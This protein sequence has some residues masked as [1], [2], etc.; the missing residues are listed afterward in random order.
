[1]GV[2]PLKL[3]KSNILILILIVLLG[4]FLRVYKLD[5][6]PPGLTWD[7][8]SLGYNAYSLSQTGKDEYGTFL[9]LTL[10][11][12]GD[13]KPALYAYL[14]I[15]FILILDLNEIAVR[16]PS[17]LAGIGLIIVTY[18][19][20]KHTFKN[21]WL[22]LSTALFVAITPL[23][24]QFSR[25]AFESNVAVFLNVLG[26]YI[27][28]KAL[29]NPRYHILAA[30]VFTLS[31]LCYQASK[32]FVPV[33]LVGL[34]L[35]FRKEIN[36]SKQLLAGLAIII[37]AL[38]LV[39]GS[40]FF[41]GQSDRLATQNFFAYTRS[42][43]QIKQ[44]SGED[45][46]IPG[47]PQFEISHGEWFAYIRGLVERY[48][49]YFSPKMLFID[50]DYSPRHSVPDLGML[51]FYGLIFIPFGIYLLYKKVEKTKKIIFFWLFT[52][53]IPAV[54]S[55]D[56]ISAVRA[57]NII[58]PLSVLEGFGL[59]YLITKLALLLHLK[60]ILTAIPLLLIIFANVLLYSDFYF[61]HL[62][63]EYSADWLYGYKQVMQQNMDFSKYDKVI[64]SDKYGQPYIYYL[65]YSKYP[66]AK[67]QAQ[68]NLD[69]NS[70]DVGTVRK[71]DNIEFR[72]IYWPGDRGI[73]N[74]LFIGDRFSLPEQDIVSE[75]KAGKLSEIY[76]LNGTNA[77]KIVETGYEN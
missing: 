20:I 15:P 33:I 22:A 35:F 49:I 21:N 63:K 74:S 17:V 8:A 14:D 44:I 57:L 62:P 48:V 50:G 13:Y 30:I 26:L 29:R 31:L 23:S 72:P 52:A 54:L 53:T 16:L 11:S 7:E 32:I 51:N 3:L 40:T 42:D 18:L 67:Y 25:A 41:L 47:A 5:S 73:E 43:E 68:A 39:Y 70:T 69:Q 6:I 55:R 4:L 38:I 10:K 61:T 2:K 46:L 45:Y 37:T 12:F 9:P 66:P 60:K 59:Y 36:Y 58:F 71:I 19:L 56:L 28:L 24:I 1:M 34:F 76:Y 64:F 65:F 77:F 27:F 75:K